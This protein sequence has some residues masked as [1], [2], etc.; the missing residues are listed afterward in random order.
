MTR[1]DWDHLRVWHKDVYL[2]LARVA[3]QEMRT[4]TDAMVKV[5]VKRAHEVLCS[6]THE[7]ARSGSLLKGALLINS[8]PP[9]YQAMIDEA[10]R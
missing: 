8:Y 10:L 5:A 7:A 1:H 2:G 9:I 3:I 6:V 4:P